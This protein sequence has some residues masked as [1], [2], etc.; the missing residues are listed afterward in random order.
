MS[1]HLRR[2]IDL[3]PGGIIHP[4]SAH[5]YRFHDNRRYVV[6]T[7]TSWIRLWV[8]WPSVQPDAAFAVDD[9]ANPGFFRLQALDEQVAAACA[10]GVRVLLA[11]YRFP[12]WANGTEELAA[13]RNTDFEV[14][15]AY[16]DRMSRAAWRRYV[17]AGRDPAQVN[18]SRRGLE[19]RIP[20]DG[21]GPDSHWARFFAF[22]YARYHLGQAASGR[23]AHGFDLVNEPNY[24]LWPQRG[25]SPT[26][27]P[28]DPGPLS[29]QHTVAAMMATAQQV[30]DAHGNTTLLF[31]PSCADSEIV[32]RTVTQY[33]EFA[34]A[35][36]D[37]LEAAGQPAGP[38][39]AWAH[40]NYTDLERRA[41]ES[42]L[43]KLRAVL[44]GRWTGYAEG[45]PPTVFVTE[46]GVRVSKMRL[47]YPDEDPLEA[48]ARSLLEGWERHARDDGAGAG[49]AMLAQYLTYTDPRF[50]AGL[51][52]PWPS[53]RRRP[54]YDAWGSLPR[55][56]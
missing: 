33:D 17:A 55:H 23:F 42:Y 11:P 27:D 56:E 34:A 7:N 26:D 54:I 2:I 50:D 40:H 16:P 20:P 5:D 53:T 43:Q 24:Q 22:L 35:L 29:V 47:Y 13:A 31:A 6:E 41:G 38:M 9:P 25:P 32:S 8:D 49:V 39:M 18:P 36:L 30:A 48:Q 46:G 19:T 28:F 4:G 51:L 52:D 44:R 14:S 21:V 12:Y 10:D 15:F 3:G 1:S 37:A 45:E